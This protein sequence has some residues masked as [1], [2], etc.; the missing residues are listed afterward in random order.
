LSL[1]LKDVSDLGKTTKS[2]LL[3]KATSVIPFIR[4]NLAYILYIL[5]VHFLNGFFQTS[6]EGFSKVKFQ[7]C[8]EICI[9]IK[10]AYVDRDSRNVFKYDLLKILIF[11]L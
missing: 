5:R 7:I 3:K 2:D 9:T 8:S 1:H 10:R 4:P 11:A 6:F